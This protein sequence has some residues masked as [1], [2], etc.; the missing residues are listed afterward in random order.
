[1]LT[2]LALTDFMK[3]RSQLLSVFQMDSLDFNL[4]EAGYYF[5][6]NKMFKTPLK[7]FLYCC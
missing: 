4:C 7:Q 2:L 6:Q 1:M 3:Y 5:F